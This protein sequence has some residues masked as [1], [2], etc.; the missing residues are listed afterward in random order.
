M[1][2]LPYVMFVAVA[3]GC[4]SSV[5]KESDDPFIVTNAATNVVAN[6]SSGATNG[7][8]NNDNVDP[9]NATTPNPNNATTPNPNNMTTPPLED[10]RAGHRRVGD[11]CEP[12]QYVALNG[13][14]TERLDL[15]M[16]GTTL[17]ACHYAPAPMGVN[18]SQIIGDDGTCTATRFVFA[19]NTYEVTHEFGRG[20]FGLVTVSGGLAPVPLSQDGGENYPCWLPQDDVRMSPMFDPGDVLTYASNGGDV[21]DAFDLSIE[22]PEALNLR[23][24]PFAP[25]D[26]VP[27]QWSGA[28]SQGMFLSAACFTADESVSVACDVNDADGAFTIPAAMTALMPTD[29]ISCRIDVSRYNSVHLEPDGT[30]YTLDAYMSAYALNSFNLE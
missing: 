12:V 6:N 9:N 10:C 29:S 20:D 23:A 1:R 25:G 14:Y 24:D 18:S 27:I 11:E 26:P 5:D 30:N 15:D 8:D 16:V 21:I 28:A 7:A 13:S 2:Y 17:V 19:N 22:V 3:A 4:S